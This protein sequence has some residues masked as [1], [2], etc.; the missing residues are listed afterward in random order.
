[1]LVILFSFVFQVL[2]AQTEFPCKT[3]YD[4]L[5]IPHVSVESEREM[6]YCWGLAH[7]QDRAWEMDFLRRVAQ[8][9]NAEVL[10]FSQLKSDLMMKLLNL[11]DLAQRL[12][13]QMPSEKRLL[14]KAYASGAN[15]GF[16]NG[17]RSKEFID[18]GYAPEMWRAQDSLLVLLL[19]SFDQTRKTFLK[20]YDEAVSQEKFGSQAEAL[21][22]EDA[23][24]WENTILKQGE[25]FRRD[26]PPSLTTSTSLKR[27]KLWGH[28][29]EVFGEESGS[30]NWAISR[31]KSKTGHAILA[32]DPHLDLK[33]PM[34]WYWIAI[35]SPDIRLIGATVPGVPV[36]ASGTNGKVAWGLTNSYLNS[37]EARLVKDLTSSDVESFWPVVWVKFGFLKIPFFFKRFER[38]RSKHPVLPLD[39]DS[40]DKL[41]LRWTGFGLTPQDVVPMFDIAKVNTV[42]EID[43]LLTDLGVPSW[44]FVFADSQGDI[45]YRLVGKTYLEKN[46]TS[47]GVRRVT[48]NEFL[49]E[50]YLDKRHRPAILRPR[51]N[52]V[53]SANNRHWP[54]DAKFY[55]GRGY[56]FSF[57]GFRIEQL[58][59][60]EHDPASFRKIQC[61]RQVVDARFFVPKLRR[62]LKL[63][64]FDGWDM[65]AD[66]NSL[67]L[68]VYRRLMDLIFERWSVNEYALYKMLNNLPVDKQKDLQTIYQDVL[69][70]IRGRK[71]GDVLKVSFPH[72][73]KNEDWIF[74]P[75]VS[76]FGDTH[77]VDPG[78]ARWN[79]D[80]NRYE[81]NS[82]ASMRMIIELTNQ[83]PRIWLALP[84]LNRRYEQT[85]DRS[86][87]Q[88]WKDCQYSEVK[89]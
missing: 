15:K 67:E 36:V 26:E 65:M 21:F 76:G 80:R 44:N 27:L 37:A 38:L 2:R 30:N 11:P 28:F 88:S 81:Q 55:G 22:D 64:E 43:K 18:Q 75:Q 49:Q 66:E 87:W 24:P 45:G 33:T 4:Q 40:D 1:M 7:G 89:F 79:K 70:E 5:D 69:K 34:F 71:W 56:S 39:L 17:K 48:L 10:G 77:S 47:F 31:K 50:L 20:N 68:P 85:H 52:Y 73:S 86:P 78:T 25:Y 58:L 53:Y 35:R 23:M 60:G 3:I 63:S 42:D 16:I 41:A 62:Y 84:G 13:A 74:S 9:R 82:G 6:Y 8:G 46:K 29:P 61:D 14:L 72:L 54:A 57:R 83:G 19:Q 51:R 12:W 32:N 59:R